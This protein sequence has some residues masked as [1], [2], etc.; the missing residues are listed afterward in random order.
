MA[1][2]AFGSFSIADF[3]TVQFDNT[4]LDVHTLPAFAGGSD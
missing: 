3:L 2:A 4:A 1:Q